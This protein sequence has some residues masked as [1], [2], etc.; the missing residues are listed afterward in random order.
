MKIVFVI[1]RRVNAGSIQAVASYVRAG[2]HLGHTFALYGPPDRRFPN[3]RC[4]TDVASADFV[5]F[6]FE[7]N[8]RWLSGLQLVHL[9]AQVPRARRAIVDADGMYNARI[10][11]DD[12][13][14]NHPSEPQRQQWLGY[15]EQLADKILQPTP[16]P[17]ERNVRPVLFYGYDPTM[18]RDEWAAIPK[19]FDL[20]HLG[21]NWWRWREVRDVLLPALEQIRTQLDGVCFIGSWWDAAPPWASALGLEAAF[22][23]DP[24]HLR[25][26]RIQIQPPIPFSEVVATM[27]AARI[28]LMTQRPLFRH[29]RFLTSKFFEIF[30]ADTIPLVVLD[31]EHASWVY[32]EAGREL[33][34]HGNMADKLVDV[35]R[36]PDEYRERVQSVRRYL[37]THHSYHQRVEELITALTA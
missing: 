7:S 30:C 10:C 37:A 23:V 14:R 27:S 17:L 35:I 18:Q 3:L 11:V 19:R 26:L 5:V 15:Y 31:P 20:I 9:L 22:Q 33:A 6:I 25:R 29:L 21:H 1:D 13:D 4:T 28:N 16:R 2:D 34:L 8:L 36:H 32:G 12:Y 24:E